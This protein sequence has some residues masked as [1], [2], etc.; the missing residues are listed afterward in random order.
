MNIAIL[1]SGQARFWSNFRL[2]EYSKANT[3]VF[4]HSWSYTSPD[5]I[6]R[7]S[8]YGVLNPGFRGYHTDYSANDNLIK[9]LEPVSYEISDFEKMEPYFRSD[10]KGFINI[11]GNCR[12]SVL[13][14][15]YSMS[16]AYNLADNFSRK[17]NIQFDLIVRTRFDVRLSKR[18]DYSR[19]T[20]N[21]KVYI[22]DCNHYVGLNDNFAIGSHGVMGVYSNIYN[23]LMKNRDTKIQLNPELILKKF[24]RKREIHPV[25][26]DIDYYLER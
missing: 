4:L 10:S 16:R 7:N 2:D 24:L 1:I 5:A 13:P 12:Y 20:E 18:L 6:R 21:N 9:Y 3:Y 15:F 14:M 8:C 25:L 17:H 19:F 26:C 23:Y 22:P 11:E